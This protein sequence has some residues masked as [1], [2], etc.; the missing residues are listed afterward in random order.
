MRLLAVVLV[1]A[2]TSENVVVGNLQEVTSLKAIPNHELDVLFVVDNS[3][4]MLDK[5]ESLAANF[6][7]MIDVLATL[8]DGVPDL[9]I[10]VVTSDLGTS[11][12]QT[13][14][15]PGIGSGPGQCRGTGD[16]GNLQQTAAMTERYL[17]DG[18]YSGALRDAFAQLAQVGDQGC[19]FE[20]H[21]GAMRRALDNNTTNAGFL[22]DAANLA[23]VILADED[24]CSV[25]D[26]AFFGPDTATLGPLQSFRCFRFGVQCDPDD[27][28]PGDKTNCRPRANSYLDDVS[29]YA[30]FLVGL[31][32][33]ARRV[34]VAGVVGDPAPV[35]VELA[36]PPGG[37][38]AIPT[39]AHSCTFAG[40]NGP[41]VADPSV[42][43][44]SFLDHFPGRSRLTSI[45]NDDLSSA[46]S[47]I[48]ESAKQLMGDPCLDTS[49]LADTSDAPGI[50]PACEVADVRDAAPTSPTAI[51]S[52]ADSA[53][54]CYELAA[55]PIACPATP[56][57]L[58]VQIHRT[59][60]VTADTWTHVRCQPR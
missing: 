49:Q 20:Q 52:C 32:S 8:D 33:D 41:E 11:G 42:R 16:A 29:P 5:Q 3:P 43:I 40:L 48:G 44:A 30:D 39:L 13:A 27:N 28:A 37:G 31:K 19:G 1:A 56:D 50:Q 4:S 21:L 26:S 18:N 47:D 60:D 12:S 58:R 51:P 9:H 36:P 35:A 22:R 59:G 10:G 25:A 24:D 54:T 6:P 46:V 45:C 38:P 57:H 53:G 34:M 17:A 14:P 2:C 23:V 55:D 7:R 15:A